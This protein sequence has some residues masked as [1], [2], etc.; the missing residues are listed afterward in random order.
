M[1]Y[2][3]YILKLA[4]LIPFNASSQKDSIHL[5]DFLNYFVRDYLPSQNITKINNKVKSNTFSEKLIS[6]TNSF[7]I[8]LRNDTSIFSASEKKLFFDQLYNKAEEIFFSNYVNDSLLVDIELL[9]HY[10]SLQANYYKY[11]GLKYPKYSVL[12]NQ[13]KISEIPDS[14]LEVR[15]VYNN[16]YL[17][18][19]KKKVQIST[20]MVEISKP[21]F[22]DSFQKCVVI[23]FK[24]LN[25]FRRAELLF[26]KVS[27][28]KWELKTKIDPNVNIEY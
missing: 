12:Y 19:F 17:N 22:F 27:N 23:T 11:F 26:F 28:L 8:I 13:G 24:H 7:S 14:I 18:F 20:R 1:K 4:L 21:F 3:L 2:P 25:D 6:Y 5:T 9:Y 10:D 16:L 15:N